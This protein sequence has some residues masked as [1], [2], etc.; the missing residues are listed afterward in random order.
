[1]AMRRLG[2][3]CVFLVMM[4]PRGSHLLDV[5]APDQDSSGESVVDLGLDQASSDGVDVGEKGLETVPFQGI[6][7]RG[8]LKIAG[9]SLSRFTD[10][11]QEALKKTF[12]AVLHV[13]EKSVAFTGVKAVVKPPPAP[14]PLD[15]NSSAIRRLLQDIKT[16]DEGV[17]VDFVLKDLN[18]AFHAKAVMESLKSSMNGGVHATIIAEFYKQ[19]GEFPTIDQ[20]AEI[21]ITF[22]NGADP[23][24][25]GVISQ[26]SGARSQKVKPMWCTSYLE[27]KDQD[28]QDSWGT[29]QCRVDS[30]VTF[31]EALDNIDGVICACDG[32]KV[33]KK[34]KTTKNPDFQSVSVVRGAAEGT[35]Y[36]SY[37]LQ[38][39]APSSVAR[40]SSDG[41]ELLWEFERQS[42]DAT[43]G[44]H[45]VLRRL[46]KVRFT[47]IVEYIDRD[48]DKQ[49]GLSDS[50]TRH[51]NP[52]TNLEVP[53]TPCDPKGEAN[54]K[55][56]VAQQFYLDRFKEA[57][58]ADV[59]AI[60]KSASFGTDLQGTTP[61][62]NRAAIDSKCKTAPA[63]K[64]R[65]TFDV[66]FAKHLASGAIDFAN[67]ELSV[68]I[69]EFPYQFPN[70]TLA[71]QAN[72]Y[73][74]EMSA[75][76]SEGDKTFK[77]LSTD[78]LD[79]DSTPAQ[80][81]CPRFIVDHNLDITWSKVIED[82]GNSVENWKVVTTQPN[83]APAADPD[84][85]YDGK[86]LSVQS[87][88]F[89]FKPDQ[90]KFYLKW[91][92]GFTMK[93]LP[94]TM[95]K[96]GTGRNAPCAGG[97]IFSVLVLLWQ[98]VG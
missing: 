6:Q 26:D 56:C 91:K 69:A 67:T 78:N 14:I 72:I 39:V 89:S 92:M 94:E 74:L 81:G 73:T 2:T 86:P 65:I 46:V 16:K 96:S 79:C 45:A 13:P 20:K 38:M 54:G 25:T 28:Q 57:T 85:Q 10:D 40:P 60:G 32:A 77:Q 80:S 55:S 71:L 62:C 53:G 97:A 98:M 33:V 76:L 66:S 49:R 35:K 23:M 22:L 8:T 52:M 68:T 4:S 50:T 64:P 43:D 36:K 24:M 51:I 93:N 7:V 84:N 41:L 75:S 95:K 5:T 12:E 88:W 87:T 1:M 63:A 17:S 42:N 30:T 47:Q 11:F 58:Y 48:T 44:Q 19:R 29:S 9:T 31:K 34:L 21:E 90:K 59:D 27:G 70:S 37:A 18:S 61:W 82:A 83:A 15:S 3:L